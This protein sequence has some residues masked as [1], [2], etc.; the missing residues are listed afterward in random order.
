MPKTLKKFNGRYYDHR[1][2][3]LGYDQCYVMADTA[4]EVVRMAKKVCEHTSVTPHE[5]RVYWHKGAIGNDMEAL[6]PV[7]E[8]GFW[9]TSYRHDHLLRL[10]DTEG[11]LIDGGKGKK[12][13]KPK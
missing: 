4:A 3:Q 10:I 7:P 1:Y 6:Y 2:R 12:I 5:I 8:K 11:N 9:L 13:P